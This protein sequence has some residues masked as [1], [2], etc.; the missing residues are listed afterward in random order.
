MQK[1]HTIAVLATL[2]ALSALVFIPV[3]SRRRERTVQIGV[4][5][6]STPNYEVYRPLLEEIIEPD[7]NSYVAK[8]P[9]FRFTPRIKFDFLV[10]NA[11][12][13]AET[14]QEKIEMF[15]EMGVD[16]VIGGM[17]SS[18][19][20]YSL[21]YVNANDMLLI[22][23]SSTA[24]DLAIPGDNLFRL[25]PDDNVQGVIIARMMETKGV[26]NA[27]V[28]YR[29]DIWGNG[30]YGVFASEYQGNIL[31]AFSYDPEETDFTSYLT[32]ADRAAENMDDVGV[33]IISFFEGRF[34]VG[35]SINYPNLYNPPWFGTETTGRS[36]MYLDDAPDQVTYLK[37]Y[38]ALSTP[39][40]S[41]K[42]RDLSVRYEQLTGL[43]ASYYT[44]TLA[45]AAWIV[46]QAVVE[47]LPSASPQF[48]AMDV[49]EV[50]PD[51]AWRHYGYS[52]YCLLDEAG[53]RY[54][55]EFDIWAY[56]LDE[57]WPSYKVVGSYSAPTGE[58]IW[59]D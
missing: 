18:Q 2:L 47:T 7:I 12:A 13:S 42:Y 41:P 14:H 36:Q 10:K 43:D 21:D 48:S 9:R 35:E 20:R 31:G 22:S 33:L 27:I 32:L 4:V 57:G 49:I 8:L 6:S 46:A 53:D 1:K 17:W 45:D 38:S 39:P 19:A 25:C 54:T 50:L 24:P 56:Y 51:I 59:Y 52:G 28:F 58:L 29:D 16:L 34:I 26:E 23:Q 37:V 11:N 15:H 55:T 5:V 30:V 3:S 40:D 44:T